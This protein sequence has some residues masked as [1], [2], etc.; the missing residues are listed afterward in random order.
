LTSL[1]Y[2]H[3]LDSIDILIETHL[4]DEKFK[5][6]CLLTLLFMLEMQEAISNPICCEG[7]NDIGNL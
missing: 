1:S 4:D 3:G 7:R 2:S 6:I 5:K